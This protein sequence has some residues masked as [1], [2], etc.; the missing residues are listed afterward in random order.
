MFHNKKN[1]FGLPQR[2]I[3]HNGGKLIDFW[4]LP[5]MIDNIVALIFSLS[6]TWKG[7]FLS[8]LNPF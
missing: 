7:Y 1:L 6:S 4:C 8:L 3:Q 5:K 2:E